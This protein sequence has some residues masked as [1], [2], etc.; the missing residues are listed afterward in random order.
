MLLFQIRDSPNLEDQFPV[1]ISPRN[2]VAQLHPQAWGSLFVASY[3]F[4]GYDGG[5][6][7]R[8]HTDGVASQSHIATDGQLVSTGSHSFLPRYTRTSSARTA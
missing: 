2:S 6:R 8:L 4:Q 1:F 3:D 7:L 5:I